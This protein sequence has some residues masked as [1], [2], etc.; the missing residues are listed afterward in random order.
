MHFLVFGAMPKTAIQ[1]GFC[2]GSALEFLSGRGCDAACQAG[3][4]TGMQ[5][6]QEDY[7]KR[8]VI[9]AFDAIRETVKDATDGNPGKSGTT[10]AYTV[11][12][13]RSLVW[14]TWCGNPG[15]TI[16]LLLGIRGCSVDERWK[17][18]PEWEEAVVVPDFP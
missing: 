14:A 10:T 4:L 5:M 3:W 17:I 16:R 1:N 18:S 13:A 7:G 6:T 9:Q 12:L 15:T 11:S 8:R 2:N